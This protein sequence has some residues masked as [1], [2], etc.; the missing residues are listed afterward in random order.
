MATAEETRE[1]VA[2]AVRSVIPSKWTVYSWPSMTET[3]PCVVVEGG[4]PYQE[5]GTFRDRDLR[6]RLRLMHQVTAG[7]RGG[8][9]IDGAIDLVLPALDTLANQGIAW[10]RVSSVGDATERAGVSAVGAFIDLSPIAI[11]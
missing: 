11:T 2:D 6:L 9:V 4:S 3:L 1:S 10:E 8:H 7:E 5:R